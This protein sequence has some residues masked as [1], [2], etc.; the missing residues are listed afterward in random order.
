MRYTK[1]VA[2][3]GDQKVFV[4]DN[5]KAAREIGWRPE[6]DKV[7]GLKQMLKWTDTL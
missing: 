7:A 2:R 4:A 1:L 6:Q 5:A 3:F